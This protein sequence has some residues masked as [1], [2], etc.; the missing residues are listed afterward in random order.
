MTF[1]RFNYTMKER[2]NL[3]LIQIFSFKFL[4]LFELFYKIYIFKLGKYIVIKF[5]EI[6]IYL[7]LF[8]FIFN[9][10][11]LEYIH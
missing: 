5:V 4:I 2:N 3:N 10:S 11:F 8:I 7:D 9:K 6:K 1:K